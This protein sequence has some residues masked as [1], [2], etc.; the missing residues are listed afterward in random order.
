MLMSTE[1]KGCVKW[2]KYFLDLLWVRFN[3]AKFH[4]YRICVTDFGE[5]GLFTPPP[6]HLWAVLKKPIL[7]RV[8]FWI[9][10]RLWCSISS[11]KIVI[12]K[13][14]MVPPVFYFDPQYTLIWEKSSQFGKQNTL[15]LDNSILLK[16]TKGG[17]NL[18]NMFCSLRQ[19]GK[20]CQF[21]D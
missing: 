19:A 15:T 14:H 18:H 9:S 12:I 8:N 1:R 11:L 3:C 21:M 10:N 16:Q 7:N 20:N 6:L 17:K 2:F 4:H 5:G 13:F